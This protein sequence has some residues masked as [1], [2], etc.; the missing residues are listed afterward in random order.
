M[1][2]L[3]KILLMSAIICLACPVS[4]ADRKKRERVELLDPTRTLRS[5]NISKSITQEKKKKKEE[6]I[7]IDLKNP[8]YKGGIL[9]TREGGVITGNE[10]RIQA[11]NIQYI[12][13]KE[14]K[15]VVHR[16]E[17]EGDLLFQ[18]K[19][20][21]FTGDELEYDFISQKGMIYNGRTYA[22]PWYIG[23]DKIEIKKDGSYT[24]TGVFLTAC[25]NYNSSW[26]LS[27]KRAEIL[28]NQFFTAQDVR[29]R[30]FKFPTLWLPSFKFNLKKFWQTP[31][32]SYKVTFDKWFPR[33]SIRARVYS[34]KDFA[35]FVRGD[36]RFKRGFGGALETEYLP[37][38]RDIS[39]LTKNYLSSDLVP[40]DPKRRQR[41]RVQGSFDSN[42]KDNNTTLHV[43][44]DKFSDINMP[45][46]FK[47]DDFEVSTAKRTEAILNH[48]TPNVIYNFYLHPRV[49][50]FATLKQEVP[51]IYTNIRPFTVG[52]TPFISANTFKAAYLNLVYSDEI[53]DR[54]PHEAAIRL[55]STNDLSYPIN[56][57]PFTFTP[58]VGV[59]GIFY[60]NSP[61]KDSVVL[62]ALTYGANLQTDLS[63]H[64]PS[65]THL[66]SPYLQFQGISKPTSS[67]HDHFIFNLQD[68]WKEL[69][70]IQL[71]VKNNF[72]SNNSLRTIP[73]LYTNLYTNAF[74]HEKETPL[75]IPRIYLDIDWNLPSLYISTRNAWNFENN[76]LDYTRCR[77]GWTISEDLALTAEGRYRSKFSWRKSDSEN[78]VLEFFRSDEELLHSPLSDSRTSLVTAL[79]IRLTPFWSCKISSH[80]GWNRR[81]EP[82]YNEFRVDLFARL[83]TSW[84]INLSYQHSEKDNRVSFSYSLFKK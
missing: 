3:I 32:I 22:P 23:G 75:F 53:H 72:F 70:L 15:K 41:Y 50:S 59:V 35:L 30:L 27:A 19:G 65:Y 57:S 11:K 49:N 14:N 29:F 83:S 24:V 1:K 25:E 17:A 56:L 7:T 51:S 9:T 60:S 52:K 39:F 64:Y 58:K 8:S 68:A 80:H 38:G 20:R 46:D 37:K 62:G 63:K 78:Y 73:A 66:I 47:S 16:I 77:F 10:L 13:R 82:D 6:V 71:G 69:N 76:I 67:M 40:N 36:Y 55:Q 74:F 81:R 84:E 48:F 34:T 79:F 4:G 45:G 44:W 43:T 31:A 26:D 2:N 28:K 18:Y 54:L 33:P 21:V 42:S 61:E 5:A 12:R